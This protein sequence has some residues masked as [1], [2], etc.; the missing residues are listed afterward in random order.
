MSV[1]GIAS[2]V[3][4][5]TRQRAAWVT[6]G[7]QAIY[8]NFAL[9]SVAVAAM[10]YGLVTHDFSIGY[11]AQVGSRSTPVFY[12]VISLWGALEGSILFW[13]WVLAMYSAVVVYTNRQRPGGLVPWSG[14]ALLTICLFFFILLVGPAN[15]WALVSPT[16]L[17][18]PGPNPLLQNHIL[19][20]VHPPLLY[21]GYVGM[22]VP[23]AFA[24]GALLSGEIHSAD[25]IKLTRRWTLS[26][27]AFLS[28]A[29]IA[30][31]WWS[32]EVLGWGGYWAWD[33]VENASFMPWLTATA[34]LHSVMVQERRGML[35]L[36]NV[37][38]IVGTFL[39]TI[40]GT[41]LTRSG[42]ISS[43]HAFTTGTIGYFFLGFI[44]LCII[45]SLVL[46]AGNSEKLRSEGYLDSAASRETVFLFN[47]LFLTG[48]TLVVVLGTLY[49]LVADAFS[50]A[51]VTVGA[52]FFNKMTIPICVSLL[53]LMGVGP[54]LPWKAA[55]PEQLKKMFVVPGAIAV[56]IV[57]IALAGGMRDV[58]GMGAF[59]FAGFALSCNLREYAVGVRARMRAHGE[60]MPVALVRLVSA[61]RRRY[62]GYLAH[63]GVIMVAAAITASSSFRFEREATLKPGQIMP[64]KGNLS[65]RVK[66]L[67]GKDEPQRQVVGADVEILHGS[68]VVGMLDPRMNF[69]KSQDQPVPTPA[70]RS[71]PDG[72]VY[73]N[74]MA[75][76]P[77]GQSATLR[78]IVEPFVPWIWFGG[79]VVA[80]GAVVSAWPVS[81]RS[82][83]LAG[84]VAPQPVVMGPPGAGFAGAALSSTTA[85]SLPTS[86]A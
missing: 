65:V 86:S 54:S 2:A 79:L 26:A 81:R 40:L 29:I 12:T 85:P 76:T 38:L 21:L 15:P 73:I 62:G 34:F 52:P 5:L 30:G 68:T 11:V 43:V 4:G 14:V 36:W 48:F 1:Y 50:G 53:F 60:A 55:T 46:V 58:Y 16:P 66:S 10:V 82:T 35:K 44:A 6:S 78:V 9:L 83:R 45:V 24:V 56:L 59:A 37:N 28:L 77:D 69:Y 64:V 41:F 74:L 75:Y 32:Y 49:P 80:L 70:V 19:M 8:V 3:V 17:D 51:K 57:V 20:A 25:W 22:S 7:M 18:G 13:G 42:I 61:N 63:M 67:W 47:N 31:M 71:R 33:P 72:D 23:F 39:L 84:F 27:W